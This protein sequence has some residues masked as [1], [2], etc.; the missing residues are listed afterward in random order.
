M[1]TRVVRES[2]YGGRARQGLLRGALATAWAALSIVGALPATGAQINGNNGSSDSNG[3]N[4]NGGDATVLDA[5]DALRRKDRNRLA[6]DRAAAAAA[7]HPLAMWVEY[8][9]LQNRIA[10]VQQPEV[11]EFSA[12]WR[13]SYVED[14]FRND[15]LLELGKRRDWVNFAAEYPRF[16]M[17][18]DREVTCY[19][20]IVDQ[21]A[22][23]DVH[24]AALAAWLA[25][26]DADDGCALLAATLVDAKQ[27]GPE[28][29][30][31]KARFAVDAG[32]PRAARQAGVLVGT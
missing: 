7:N 4:N 31:R 1:T 21:A 25:Q 24:D 2:V 3:I 19:A 18:D 15:W 23:K 30:W 9:E 26:R 6:V 28:E 29:L 5:R 32:R 14:R 11:D 8:W 13:G 10:D 16:R 27:F 22:G 12:H 17:N 20:L